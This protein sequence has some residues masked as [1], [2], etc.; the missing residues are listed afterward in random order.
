MP[1]RKRQYPGTPPHLGCEEAEGRGRRE[2][3]DPD[4]LDAAPLERQVAGVDREPFVAG[5]G[6]VGLV[7]LVHDGDAAEPRQGKQRGGPGAHQNVYPPLARRLVDRG[8]V[9][10]QAAVVCG[11]REALRERA[12]QP[13]RQAFGRLYLGDQDQRL[14]SPFGRRAS[15]GQDRD[16]L[17][18]GRHPPHEGAA[19]P[20]RRS[21]A[22]QERLQIPNLP[23]AR[24]DEDGGRLRAPLEPHRAPPHQLPQRAPRSAALGEQGGDRACAASL[25][26]QLE[27][28]ALAGGTGQIRRGGGPDRR[29]LDPRRF[30]DHRGEGDPTLGLGLLETFRT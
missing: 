24:G 21:R 12:P 29:P 15:Q 23:F 2:A 5:L 22:A 14:L 16:G 25:S 18:R 1:G 10:A 17:L 4:A 30:R 27:Q 3:E 6:A 11:H 9:A 8:A 20:H 7:G 28:P 13:P 19:A 26:E